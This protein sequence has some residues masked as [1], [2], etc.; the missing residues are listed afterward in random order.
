MKQPL[1][2]AIASSLDGT[3]NCIAHAE[4]QPHL[5]EWIERHKDRALAL[6]RE[7]MPSGS[8]IDNG[9]HLYVDECRDDKLVFSTSYH[10]MNDGGYY[11]GW[12]DHKIIVRPSLIHT[13]DITI[14][15][16]NRNDIKDYLH[17]VY[18][19]ALLQL[20]GED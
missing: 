2:Q 1:Y 7:H 3:R 6:T 9:T 8:G 15:G 10:H 18:S 11:D 17:D 14:T 4:A 19:E 13:L 12:T 16:R 5:A 20:I